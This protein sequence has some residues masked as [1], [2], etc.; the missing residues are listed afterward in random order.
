MV[1]EKDLLASWPR[2]EM[3]VPQNEK[4]AVLSFFTS[5]FVQV[6]F[7]V[8]NLWALS[9]VQGHGVSRD[10]PPTILSPAL[11]QTRPK[12]FR[13]NVGSGGLGRE[14]RGVLFLHG[15]TIH[16][17]FRQCL[18]LLLNPTRVA[19]SECKGE[20]SILMWSKT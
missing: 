20:R 1:G 12:Y 13:I 2:K 19:Y 14:G 9:A 17:N 8:V 15:G 10:K 18:V 16:E 7:V 3:G 4:E 11:R 5:L 6:F